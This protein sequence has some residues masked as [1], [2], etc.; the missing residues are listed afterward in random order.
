MTANLVQCYLCNDK[1]INY[2]VKGLQK[3]LTHTTPERIEKKEPSSAEIFAMS[4]VDASLNA[5]VAINID[6][7]KPIPASRPAPVICRQEVLAGKVPHLSLTVIK[8]AVNIPRG[9]PIS[10]PA[11]M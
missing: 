7:V 6:M 10:K 9:L 2:A 8:H 5:S 11:I 3:N 1:K 4:I